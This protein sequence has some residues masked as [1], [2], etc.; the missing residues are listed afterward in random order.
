MCGG[1]NSSAAEESTQSGVHPADFA[2]S[3]VLLPTPRDEPLRKPTLP[4]WLHGGRAMVGQLTHGRPLF[5]SAY[6]M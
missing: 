4:P 6:G 2:S 3:A 5:M 1:D